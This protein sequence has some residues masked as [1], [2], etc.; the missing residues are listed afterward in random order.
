MSNI[1]IATPTTMDVLQTLLESVDSMTLSE[2]VML[3]V[4]NALKHTYDKINLPSLPGMPSVNGD[5]VRTIQL[6]MKIKLFYKKDNVP[7]CKLFKIKKYEIMRASTPNRMTIEVNGVEKVMDPPKFKK[8][9]ITTM[10]LILCYA[11]EFNCEDVMEI[12]HYDDY[13]VQK[14]KE[15][16]VEH[17]LRYDEGDEVEEFDY[18]PSDYDFDQ[19]YMGV[20]NMFQSLLGLNF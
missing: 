13:M 18:C 12:I 3:E 17:K 15:D 8:L 14:K 20:Y 7:D 4:K 10:T 16:T 2:G 6:D 5:V 9:L 11:V 19:F 1:E